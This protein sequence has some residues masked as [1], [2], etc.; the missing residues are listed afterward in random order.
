MKPIPTVEYLDLKSFMG[1]WYVIANIPTYF[2]KEA[3]NA[4]ETYELNEDGTVA[5]TFTFNK[6]SYNGDKKQ[7]N[8]KGYVKDK[9]TNALWDMQFIWPFKSEYRVIY[10]DDTYSTTIIGRNKRDY[11]WIMSRSSKIDKDKLDSLVKF[12]ADK[13]YDINK[14]QKVPQKWPAEVLPSSGGDRPIMVVL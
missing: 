1:P 12:V 5:T 9:K 7:Y 2:E 14:I 10:L 13:G 6:G 11:V 4:V 8:P 3:F